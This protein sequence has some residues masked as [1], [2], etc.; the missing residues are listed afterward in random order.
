MADESVVMREVPAS[1]VL[2]ASDVETLARFYVDALG[3]CEGLRGSGY[4]VLRRE[5]FELTVHAVPAAIAASIGAATPD[6]RRGDAAIK[7]A[8]A[9]TDL[10]LLRER[11]AKSG[12]LLGP[13]EREWS[14]PGMRAVDG[15]DPEGNVFQLRRYARESDGNDMAP[16]EGTKPG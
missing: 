3:F 6:M 10:A 9:V 4:T 1:A 2:F 16:V 15:V 12:G 5:G 14:M 13:P 7:L 8:F 11:V